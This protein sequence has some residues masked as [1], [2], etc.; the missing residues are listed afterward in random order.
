MWFPLVE[1]FIGLLFVINLNASI[2]SW[3]LSSVLA[4]LSFYIS[5][6]FSNASKRFEIAPSVS[7]AVVFFNWAW[8]LVSAIESE[9][10]MVSDTF[11][12][13]KFNDS[14]YISYYS[15]QCKNYKESISPRQELTSRNSSITMIRFS[16][17]TLRERLK[18]SS[19]QNIWW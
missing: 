5:I 17:Q 4:D 18:K 13:V 16:S 10:R 8:A 12:T 19:L 6:G 15:I 9:V 1:A 2:I 7:R 14:I 3:T 11:D